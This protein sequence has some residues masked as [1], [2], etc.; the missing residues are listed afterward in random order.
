M[1]ATAHYKLCF[2]VHFLLFIFARALILQN[3][4]Y[5]RA[6]KRKDT[7][8]LKCPW[9]Q[10]TPTQSLIFQDQFGFFVGNRWKFDTGKHFCIVSSLLPLNSGPR[11][12]GT[13]TLCDQERRA[14]IYK[15]DGN[16][17]GIQRLTRNW[18]EE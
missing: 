14:L 15:G 7:K 6:T 12:A 5:P 18:Q 1:L 8:Y 9:H 3:T 16:S 4:K 10:P 2:E 13:A 11:E 17:P